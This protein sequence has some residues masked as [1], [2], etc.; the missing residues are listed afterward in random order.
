MGEKSAE[1][2]LIDNYFKNLTNQHDVVVGIG[3]DGAVICS[4]NS[5]QLVV[6]TDTLVES[7]HFPPKLR[8]QKLRERS[9]ST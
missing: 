7:V 3:D 9:V 1:F 5:S 4:D 2:A 6:A 8:L